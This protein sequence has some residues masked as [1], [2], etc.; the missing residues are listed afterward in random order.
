MNAPYNAVITLSFLVCVNVASVPLVLAAIFG[1]DTFALP[2]LP[3]KWVIFLVVI[4]FGVSQYF[5]LVH[6]KKFVRIIERYKDETEKQRKRGLLY[7]WFYI[8]ISI[9]TPLYIAFFTTPK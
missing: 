6:N 3:D 2:E 1:K 5:L 8:F 9:G 7:A 4:G